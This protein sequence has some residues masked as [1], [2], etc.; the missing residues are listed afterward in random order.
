MDLEAEKQL[1]SSLKQLS[2]PL[3]QSVPILCKVKECTLK[4]ITESAGYSRNSLYQALVRG[5][6]P[7][8]PLYQSV[9][10]HLGVDPWAV[11]EEDE[12]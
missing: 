2:I 10:D 9:I 1:L 4:S 11:Y 12:G 7:K 3:H 6:R 5:T 8:Y